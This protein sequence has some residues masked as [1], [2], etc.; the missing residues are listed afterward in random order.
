MAPLQPQQ[1]R[2]QAKRRWLHAGITA[3]MLVAGAPVGIALLTRTPDATSGTEPAPSVAAVYPASGLVVA[4]SQRPAALNSPRDATRAVVCL[5]QWST[6]DRGTRPAAGIPQP[7]GPEPH[8][9]LTR[10]ASTSAARTALMSAALAVTAA[11]D[12][13]P[14]PQRDQP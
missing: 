7:E 8:T 3:V 6:P 13:G 10:R 11:P 14:A 5:Y 4:L 9:W 1:P 2:A 12:A